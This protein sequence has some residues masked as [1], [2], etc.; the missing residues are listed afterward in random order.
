MKKAMPFIFTIVACL[1]IAIGLTAIFH[2]TAWACPSWSCPV[3]FEYACFDNGCKQS[4][5]DYWTDHCCPSPP[6][7]LPC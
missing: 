2:S 4:A 7:D 3:A 6:C 1:A 5:I